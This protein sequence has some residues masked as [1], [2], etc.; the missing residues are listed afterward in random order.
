MSDFLAVAGVSAV[1]KSILDDA[2]SGTDLSTAL[3]AP[4]VVTALPPDRVLSSGKEVPQI[5]LFLYHVN[6]NPAWRNNEL[7][8]Y[9]SSGQRVRNA[10][11]P[12]NLHYFLTTYGAGE[13]DSE[14]LL[15]W[16]MQVLH[17]TPILTRTL[18]QAKLNDLAN[19]GG[20]NPVSSE[21]KAIAKT[22]LPEQIELVRIT[23]EVL[24]MDDLSKLWTAFQASYRTTAAY[25]ASVVLIQ[26]RQPTRS[27]LP[28][29]TRNIQ[30]ETFAAPV[31]DSIPTPA[32]AVG[33]TLVVLGRN[34]L[35]DDPGATKLVFDGG[36]GVVPDVV[37][38]TA[39]KLTLP[40]TLLAGRRLV[41][42]SRD[43][44]FGG[45]ADSRPG[46]QSN[47]ATFTLQPTLL[48]QPAPIAP[49]DVLSL[50]LSPPVGR[51]QSVTV[52]FG[53][54]GI[55]ADPRAPDAQA[56]SDTITV[57]IPSG[58]A[59]GNSTLRVRP[60]ADALTQAVHLVKVLLPQF[61]NRAQNRVA[62]DRHELVRLF[63]A[64]FQLVS[65]ADVVADEIADGK[66]RLIQAVE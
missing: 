9:D 66:L 4:P 40:A 11:L 55:D 37:Q 22:T 41:Q 27:A 42:V 52:F 29:Q 65:L 24:T 13:F 1:L 6:T 18:M 43:V 36:A 3:G 26:S 50:K 35:G 8:W 54:Q 63:K 47:P 34:F 64:D 61:I 23:P 28:V 30:V 33:E 44:E 12:L 57:T 2:I 7:P 46:F 49:G 14:I 56:T 58:F 45:P 32:L 10:P 25:Q 21:I 16:A 17:E 53:D 19:P 51:D 39:V 62:L 15:G 59:A 20:G 38:G 48:T 60:Q 31:I 5:N